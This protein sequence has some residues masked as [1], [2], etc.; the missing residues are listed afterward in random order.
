MKRLLPG[1][2]LLFFTYYATCQNAKVSSIIY[3]KINGS[4]LLITDDSNDELYIWLA[5][6]LNSKE[7]SS[8]FT[9]YTGSFTAM[10][11]FTNFCISAI[12]VLAD[13]EFVEFGKLKIICIIEEG[14]KFLS[15]SKDGKSCGYQKTDLSNI[16]NSLLKHVESL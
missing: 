14:N 4:I 5:P 8:E 12:D 3:E 16:K 15:I 2:L 7:E 13:S 9:I 11:K 10:I 1:L 6:D